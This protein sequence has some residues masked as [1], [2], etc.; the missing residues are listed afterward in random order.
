M[1]QCVDDT[2][3][4]ALDKESIINFVEELQG[5]GFDPEM[6]GDFAEECLGIGMQENNNGTICM[7]QKGLMSRRSLQ[8]QR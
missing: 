5:E 8:Q 4:A 6:E 2:G 3:T 7:T 1:I